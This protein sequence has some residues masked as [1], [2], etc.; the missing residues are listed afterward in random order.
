MVWHDGGDKLENKTHL[1]LH[2]FTQ[3]HGVAFFAI[4]RDPAAPY[5]R[6]EGGDTFDDHR[7]GP[8]HPLGDAFDVHGALAVFHLCPGGYEGQFQPV[9]GH[10]QE[11]GTRDKLQKQKAE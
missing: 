10:D 8:K 4:D 2:D 9:F 7:F 5:P 3:R 11:V 6:G 1:A